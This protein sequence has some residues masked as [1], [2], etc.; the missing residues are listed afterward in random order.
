MSHKQF[1]NLVH[2]SFPTEPVPQTFFW[3]EC[4][5][6]IQPD[7]PGELQNRMA[8]RRWPEV[9]LMDWLMVGVAP[10]VARSYLEPSTFLYY[11]PSLLVGVFDDLGYTDFAIEGIVPF[12]KTHTPRGKWW[13]TFSACVSESQRVALRSF[14]TMIR[15]SEPTDLRIQALLGDAD[16]I[17]KL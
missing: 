12:N 10:C 7:I 2:G 8:H 14:L 4:D 11:L 1:L 5:D 15:S 9:K 6:P 17:W 3:S 13:S 16:A